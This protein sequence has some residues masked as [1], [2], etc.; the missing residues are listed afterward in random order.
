MAT[1]VGRL[2]YDLKCHKLTQRAH[3]GR[4]QFVG[5]EDLHMIFSDNDANACKY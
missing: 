3:V 2:A 4:Q 5:M 1:R